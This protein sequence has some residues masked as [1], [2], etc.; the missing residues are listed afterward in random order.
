MQE[1]D[2]T[3]YSEFNS[4][5]MQWSNEDAA[6]EYAKSPIYHGEHIKRAKVDVWFDY[7]NYKLNNP[8]D[9][10]DGVLIETVLNSGYEF[11]N[12]LP[13]PCPLLFMYTILF[14]INGERYTL[15]LE[16]T[17]M[18]RE[19]HNEVLIIGES[20]SKISGDVFLKSLF[21]IALTKS[22]LKGG[23]FTMPV[24]AYDWEFNPTPKVDYSDILLPDDITRDVKL[25][26]NMYEELG[27][28]NKY[29]FSGIPG[30][31]KTE[32]TR[33]VSS[34]L[35]KQGVTVIK[36][37][38]CQKLR[39]KFELAEA[40][41]P[42]LII[43]DDI[44]LSLGDRNNGGYSDLLGIF[45]DCLDGINKISNKVGVIATTNAP[46][47]IDLAAQRPGRFNKM[48]FFDYLTKDNIKGI[49]IKSLNSIDSDFD[50]VSEQ[51]RKLFTDNKLIEY[52]YD[53]SVTGA[54]IYENIKA[55]K[56]RIEVT[57]ETLTPESI[58]SELKINAQ[59]LSDK[60]KTRTIKGDFDKKRSSLGYGNN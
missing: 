23:F 35:N 24:N 39:E 56:Y 20:E 60:Q 55:L 13:Q 46:H 10:S 31:G 2:D 27:V 14:K 47:L 30:T 32:S 11:T 29:M 6:L 16:A 50:N 53:S 52:F 34:I 25:Y 18:D 44:D 33:V 41:A 7:I 38:V 5:V 4:L 15:K 1:S 19:V 3:T 57:K 58:I 8:G 49:I 12:S 22:R 59:K 54:F 40:L 43:M 9:T 42:S 17:Y 21:T 45:L 51:D 48:M 36:T 28:L 26:V 37:S